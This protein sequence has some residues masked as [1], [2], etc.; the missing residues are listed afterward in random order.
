MIIIKNPDKST[1]KKAVKAI[2][3]S[4]GT[5]PKLLDK[6]QKYN[7]KDYACP[8]FIESSETTCPLG[9]YIKIDENKEDK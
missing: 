2:K 5:C 9:M 6:G 4:G 7:C 3:H 1:V 8:Y